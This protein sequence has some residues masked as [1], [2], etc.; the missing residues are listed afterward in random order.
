MT[1]AEIIAMLTERRYSLK[2]RAASLN[3]EL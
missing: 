2:F 1:I 3:H